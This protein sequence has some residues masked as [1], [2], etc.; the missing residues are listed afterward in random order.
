MDGALLNIKKQR[1][2]VNKTVIL[3]KITFFKRSILVKYETGL[4]RGRL[5]TAAAEI[6]SIF[7]TIQS[8]AHALYNPIYSY[9]ILERYI[10]FS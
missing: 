9:E 4:N 2:F 3:L 5:I 1:E 8:F 7:K 6:Y 10:S